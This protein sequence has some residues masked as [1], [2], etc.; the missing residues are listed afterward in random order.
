MIAARALASMASAPRVGPT[1]RCSTTSTGTGRAPPSMRTARSV[2]SCCVNVPVILV[3]PPGMPMSQETPGST[4]GEEMTS[5]SS[6]IAIRRIGSPG[7]EH[8]ASPVSSAH[9]C[10]PSPTKSTV[11]NHPVAVC[12]SMAASAPAT[13]SPVRA[14]G[15]SRSGWP[16]SSGSTSS[17]PGAGVSV[18]GDGE[19]VGACATPRTG[20]NVS[21]AVRPMTSAAS[22]GSSTPGSST[23]MRCSPERA[24]AGSAT[25]RASTRR[26]S[27]S[28]ARSVDS[29]SA[30]TVGESRVSRTICVPPRRS[31]PSRGDAVST[32]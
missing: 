29:A 17:A 26:R 32:T 8:A 21:C 15:P 4:W 24:S 23:K 12:G 30:C 2:A 19:A 6:T 22:R 18:P 28:R 5:S 10:S 11:T 27:T 9:P 20:W 7:G 3:S 31:R 1:V 25:P 14:A 13:P 16:D